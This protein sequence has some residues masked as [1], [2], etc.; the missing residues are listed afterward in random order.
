M[1]I[2]IETDDKLEEPEVI[3]RCPAINADV[4]QLQAALMDAL[5]AEN[6]ILLE[7]EGCEYYLSAEE[8]LFF[9]T[10]AGKTWAHTADEVFETGMRLYALETA[11]PGSFLRISKSAIVNVLHIYSIEKNITGPSIIRFRGSH[12]QITASRQYF[13]LLQDRLR[14]EIAATAASVEMR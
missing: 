3:I 2:R 13:K 11:L 12:K 10:G 14:E 7:R 4:A 6:R 1:K 9:E 5:S 8:M